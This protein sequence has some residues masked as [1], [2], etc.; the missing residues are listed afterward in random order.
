[1]HNEVKLHLLGTPV[2]KVANHTRREMRLDISGSN[3]RVLVGIIRMARMGTGIGL[4]NAWRSNSSSWRTRRTT[5]AGPGGN[6][7]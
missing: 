3:T 1:M 4:L 5:Q 7:L 2:A 6:S